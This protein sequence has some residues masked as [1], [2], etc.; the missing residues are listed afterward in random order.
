MYVYTKK[1][2][3]RER[4]HSTNVKIRSSII[5]RQNR[6]LVPRLTQFGKFI[7]NDQN[8][9]VGATSSLLY[10]G[11]EVSPR[12]S[13]HCRRSVANVR[14]AFTAILR[15]CTSR[16]RPGSSS[17]SCGS[18]SCS[19]FILPSSS[20]LFTL[21]PVRSARG[22]PLSELLLSDALL[23]TLRPSYQGRALGLVLVYRRPPH[24]SRHRF[25]RDCLP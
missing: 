13:E 17:T 20:V 11:C 15:Q 24:P 2:V 16:F 4:S 21:P 25:D 14:D 1:A 7:L 8:Y 12:V 18:S 19:L 22:V 5:E 6:Q 9:P 3:R 23:H 10:R